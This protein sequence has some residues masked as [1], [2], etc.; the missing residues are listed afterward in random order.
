MKIMSP[1]LNKKQLLNKLAS[2]AKSIT[3][4]DLNTITQKAER[5]L[6]MFR[7][8]PLQELFAYGKLML[9]LIN[10]YRSGRY[11]QVSWTSISISAAALLYVLSPLDF[12]PDVIPIIGQVD[13]VMIVTFALRFIKEE[14]DRYEAWQKQD[15]V[16][17]ITPCK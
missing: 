2:D 17:D 3:Q 7:S 9:S 11:N 1:D 5:I 12:L 15:N 8:G 13:D 10:D 14:L 16:I 6:E 4:I